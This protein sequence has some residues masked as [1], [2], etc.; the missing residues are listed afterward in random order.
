MTLTTY[1]KETKRVQFRL[2]GNERLKPLALGGDT[3]A[4]EVLGERGNTLVLDEAGNHTGG[5]KKTYTRVIRR[6]DHNKKYIGD[7]V[8]EE[9]VVDGRRVEVRVNGKAIEPEVQVPFEN[10]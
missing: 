9:D 5:L 2:Q 3:E 6:L 8:I 10:R 4:E 7:D 1:E